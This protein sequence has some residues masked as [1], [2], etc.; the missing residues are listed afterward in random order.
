MSRK[1]SQRAID[2]TWEAMLR[3]ERQSHFPLPPQHTEE[4]CPT[5]AEWR[6]LKRAFVR[7]VKE[8]NASP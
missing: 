4:A 3:I 7:A 6:R 2:R 5:C 8:R 1:S